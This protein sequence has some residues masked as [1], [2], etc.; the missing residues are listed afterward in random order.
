VSASGISGT[1]G[2]A[3][4]VLSPVPVDAA[5]VRNT[6]ATPAFFRSPY[7]VTAS[8]TSPN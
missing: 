3:V 6:G 8:C 4:Y 1:E 7:G 2:R 5:Q